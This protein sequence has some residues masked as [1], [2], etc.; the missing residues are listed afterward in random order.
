MPDTQSPAEEDA[1]ARRRAQ[2]VQLRI[3]GANFEQIGRQ[4][5]PPCSKQAAHKLWRTAMRE[6]VAPEVAELRQQ[7][8]ERLDYLIMQAMAVVRRK[9]YVLFMG[10]VVKKENPVTGIAEELVDDGPILQ[11]IATL[12]RLSES[13]RKL[14]GVDVPATVKHE[15]GVSEVDQALERARLELAELPMPSEVE[16]HEAP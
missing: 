14:W 6:I 3:A 4:L 10:E 1:Q 7:E 15:F 16:L 5:T 11:A 9:H 12:Q 8:D 2:V 13:K